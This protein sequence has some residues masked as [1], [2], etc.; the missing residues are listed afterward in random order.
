MT[1]STP[2][3]EGRLLSLLREG[4]DKTDPVPADVT[5]FARTALSWRTIDA[6]LAE[7]AY[8]SSEETP[9][10]GVRSAV[11]AR[12]LSFEVGHWTIDIEYNAATGRLI[13]QV[14]PAREVIVELHLAGGP[15]VSI[16]DELGRFDFDGVL[17]GPVSLVFR[18]AGDLEV[19]KTEWTVL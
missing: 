18:T 4:L 15:A 6:E 13:G 17:P 12:M 11:T 5:D 9:P 3:S 14:E 2:L 8:D 19:V 7:I 1:E 10:V 16:A